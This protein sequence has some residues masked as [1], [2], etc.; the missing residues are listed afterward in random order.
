MQLSSLNTEEITHIKAAFAAAIDNLPETYN[1]LRSLSGSQ[2]VEI[3]F[4]NAKE[5]TFYDKIKGTKVDI[6]HLDGDSILGHVFHSKKPYLSQNVETDSRYVLH[7][8][9][10][11]KIGMQSQLVI[12]SLF[13]GSIEGIIRFAKHDGIYS[14]ED[15][16]GIQLVQ[17]SFREIFLNEQY[18]KDMEMQR[19]PFSLESFEVYKAI[20]SVKSTY[21]MLMKHTENPE[22][23]KL[24][25][26]GRSNIDSVFEYLNPNIDNVSRVK[27]E[28]RMLN[29]K[30]LGNA[31]LKVLIAD[32][33]QMNVKIINS[34]L[35]KHENVNEILAAYDGNQA[36]DI[37]KKA[38]ESDAPVDLL[39]LDH[40]M[41]GKL[42]L[43]I[44]EIL[45]NQWKQSTCIVS[46]TNDPDAIKHRTE[47]YNYHMSKPFAKAEMEAI[48]GDFKQSCPKSGTENLALV[49]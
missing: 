35:N 33:V 30:K 21:E 16:Q 47:L 44:A 13:K 14:R 11:F 22:I 4:L 28:M 38:I 5:Q 9:N 46:I 24:L 45:K 12:P 48:L 31:G 7:I 39:F 8:D 6:K 34:L 49:V 18:L 2:S 15:L 32:D 41:P 37:L 1:Q 10:P 23:Q 29:R 43:E 42:G 25:S 17:N 40:H 26:A 20:K 19:H 3:L 36:H 27:S